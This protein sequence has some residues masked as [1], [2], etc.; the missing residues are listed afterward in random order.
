MLEPQS[1]DFWWTL[2]VGT[3]AAMTLVVAFIVALFF[4]QRTKF[5][6]QKE[7][8]EIAQAGEKRYA[9]LFNSVSDII[10]V[11]SP[12]G[13]IVQVNQAVKN[14]LGVDADHVIGKSIGELLRPRYRKEVESYLE[15]VRRSSGETISGIVPVVSPDG[16]SLSLLEY[17]S[18]QV[19]ENGVLTAIRGIARNVTEQ[20]HSAQSLRRASAR[21]QRLLEESRRMQERLAS[22]S[23]VTIRMQEEDRRSISRELHDE[24][25]QLLATVTVNLESVKKGMQRG[26]EVIRLVKRLE[27][28]KGLVGDI[29][30]RVRRCLKELRPVGFDATGLTP[31]LRRL[32][33]EFSERTGIVV[34]FNEDESS[35]LLST[36]QKIILYRV[37]QES[38]SNTAQHAHANQVTIT[39]GQA[40]G[41][42]VASIRDDGCGFDLP[43][44]E[45]S[46][47]EQPSNVHLGLIGMQERVK[48]AQGTFRIT[49]E[50]GKGT[51]IHV[52]IPLLNHKTT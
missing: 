36:D 46:L 37:V 47:S 40:D 18:T 38:L 30:E 44:Y 19:V 11:H 7:K 51:K 49:S 42:I 9:D 26:A 48:I 16:T 15:R 13:V 21:M 50:A 25:G 52:R 8:F 2:F 45:R 3:T 17:R 28:T 32:T 41:Y 27:E 22:L 4:N 20:V 39:F 6:S 12:S 29:F 31:A 14:T 5:R 33:G 1:I 34:E 35:E 23:Q 24:V 10:Y 43:A